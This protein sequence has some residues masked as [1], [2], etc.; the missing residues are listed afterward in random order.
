[1]I[2]INLNSYKNNNI[3]NSPKTTLDLNNKK[4]SDNVNKENVII[5]DECII[6]EKNEKVINTSKAKEAFE[7]VLQQFPPEERAQIVFDYFVI[8]SS[9]EDEGILLPEQVFSDNYN[10]S[11][12]YM[13]FI[14]DM[15]SYVIN[16]TNDF[17][18]KSN[19]FLD[20]CEKFQEEL[21]KLDCK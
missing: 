4:A 20:F 5:K 7:N 18:F 15:K 14:K 12:S 8:K 16:N 19:N 10:D 11:F 1:M 2:D 13:Q 3:I 17:K 9:M 21:K 6:H